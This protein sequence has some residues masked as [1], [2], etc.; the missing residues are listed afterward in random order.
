MKRIRVITT[1][2][3]IEVGN[4]TVNEKIKGYRMCLKIKPFIEGELK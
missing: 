2:K 4:V 1:K 3:G